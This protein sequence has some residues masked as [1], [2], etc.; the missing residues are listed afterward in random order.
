MTTRT[1]ATRLWIN[2]NGRVTCDNVRCAGQTAV[3]SGMRHDLNGA[4]LM[5]ITADV[6][7]LM[8]FEPRCENCR[9]RLGLKK[10]FRETSRK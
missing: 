9:A 2:G 6:R 8:D 4:E 7:G 1:G 10:V 5:E 3:S